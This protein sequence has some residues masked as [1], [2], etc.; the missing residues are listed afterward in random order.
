MLARAPAAKGT[1][2][3]VQIGGVGEIKVNGGNLEEW[4]GKGAP[5]AVEVASEKGRHSAKLEKLATARTKM[6]V[7]V[8]ISPPQKEGENL[9]VGGGFVLEIK[10]AR[11]RRYAVE[12][13][14]RRGRSPTSR[15]GARRSRTRSGRA[16][17]TFFRTCSR[18]RTGARAQPPRD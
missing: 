7:K 5:D 16:R 9:N 12:D 13:G 1:T 15:R 3:S 14:W 18:A 8:T 2:G 10:D 4:A 17:T 6:D 11:I